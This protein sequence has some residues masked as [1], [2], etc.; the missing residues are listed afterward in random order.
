MKYILASGSP[1]RKELLTNMGVEFEIMVS[2]ADEVITEK[3]PAKIVESL[4]LGK[5][6]D[7][8]SRIQTFN[9]PTVLIAADTLVFLNDEILGKP[10][11]KED[12]VRM[13]MDL[14][15]KAHE[16]IT[17]VTLMHFVSDKRETVTFHETTAVSFAELSEEE[18]RAYVE[19]G[20][21]L[22]KAG[23]Y[24]I[25]GIGARFVTGINGDYSNV[26]GL[27]VPALYKELSKRGWINV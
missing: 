22:D 9:E 18:A 8:A 12:A 14:S 24:A 16:V 6:E 2:N 1:R 23:A 26:V 10:R 5:A 7:V 13:V 25:Q 11:D 3:E 19:T 15:G 4:S 17:G 21:P 27:P 20:E